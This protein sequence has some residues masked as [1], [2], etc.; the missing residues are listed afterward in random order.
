MYEMEERKNLLGEERKKGKRNSTGIPDKM[1]TQFEIYPKFSFGDVRVSYGSKKSADLQSVA[2]T[3]SGNINGLGNEKDKI[4]MQSSLVQRYKID[5][6]CLNVPLGLKNVKVDNSLVQCA[7]PVEDTVIPKNLI[8]VKADVDAAME[9][10]KGGIFRWANENGQVKKGLDKLGRDAWVYAPSNKGESFK[11]LLSKWN[12]TWSLE[13]TCGLLLDLGNALR[14]FTGIEVKVM[15][16]YMKNSRTKDGHKADKRSDWVKELPKGAKVMSGV[17][18]TTGNL[19]KTLVY[20]SEKIELNLIEVEAIIIGAIKYWKF[21]SWFNYRH[22][23][24]WLTGSYHTPSEV[25]SVYMYY[26]EE[27]LLNKLN[28]ASEVVSDEPMSESESDT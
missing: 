15:N 23:E 2:Y 13:N 9:K 18:A 11:E 1:K 25:W 16:D 10:I 7:D 27:G 3:E 20:L 17:S 6:E 12:S 14:T 4:N 22:W 19:L 5:E 26:L 8:S 28:K 21:S 24:K